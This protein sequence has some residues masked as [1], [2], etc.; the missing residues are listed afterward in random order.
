ML[1]GVA[2][3]SAPV[4]TTK[5]TS[6]LAH[7][8]RP[9]IKLTTTDK[10]FC[11]GS[12]KAGTSTLRDLFSEEPGD[13]NPCHDICTDD[14]VTTSWSEASW[15]GIRD[16]S[17]FRNHRAFMDN[18]DNSNWM[19]LDHAFAHSRFVFNSRKM[20]DWLLSRFDQIR[21][22][23][24]K[25]GCK[26]QG[27][28]TDCPGVHW[29]DNSD[30]LMEGWI[31][32]EAQHHAE[33]HTYF[34]H[35]AHRRNRFVMIDVTDGT[36]EDVLH[37]L[38]WVLREDLTTYEAAADGLQ[39]LTRALP[40]GVER[41]DNATDAVKA[42][43]WSWANTHDK[44]SEGTVRDMLLNIGCGEDTFADRVYYRCAN[45]VY[46]KWYGGTDDLYPENLD[47]LDAVDD[48]DSE[49]VKRR[50]EMQANMAEFKRKHGA[51]YREASRRL[52]EAARLQDEKERAYSS[53]LSRRNET[54]SKRV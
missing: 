54:R 28:D 47:D 31:L 6:L 29:A 42:I 34:M 15:T 41:A 17:V 53:T 18:G 27:T 24:V 35:D 52:G 36:S 11:I 44:F 7:D 49:A 39:I 40:A 38:H 10:V 43:P 5:E 8:A 19:W 45:K 13:W 26:A 14:A 32:Y 51:V 21:D 37:R 4:S 2:A 12:N 23:R 16:Q 1:V 46:R 48:T 30:S 50:S 9:Q 25:Q 3:L 22:G 20:Y 33:M